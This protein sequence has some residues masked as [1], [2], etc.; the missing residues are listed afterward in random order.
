MRFQRHTLAFLLSF[1]G[2]CSAALGQGNSPQ[3]PSLPGSPGSI[4]VPLAPCRILNTRRDPAD[5][6]AASATRHVDVRAT[7]CGR[8]VPP[9]ALGLALKLVS[10]ST[11]TPGVERTERPVTMPAQANGLLNFNASPNEELSVDVYGYWVAPGTPVGPAT[12]SIVGNAQ[13]A[14][15]P[16]Q[17]MAQAA[18]R[19]VAQD[20]H[21]GN[22]GEIYLDA[23]VSPFTQTGVLM[24]A[25]NSVAPW[26]V[27]KA[28]TADAGSGFV[29]ANSS[30]IQLLSA[31][32]DGAVQLLNGAFLDGRT[33]YFGLGSQYYGFVAVPTNIVHDVTLIDPHDAAGGAT[34]RVV[35][36]NA[37]TDA[38]Y[39][40]PNITKYRAFTD[41][42]DSHTHINYE[43]A[44]RR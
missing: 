41:G 12:Q 25:P 10:Y 28:G 14:A 23:S 18:G 34:T 38:E 7:R 29:L 6:I 19:P 37:Q 11:A 4:F 2:I 16:F 33:D 27:A 26:I 44:E 22:K 35:F 1:L 39:G 24:S 43:A 5:N 9:Y 21:P 8:I 13:A 17:P 40:S 36:Y 20:V 15:S 32:S 30:N 3:A 31:R 42:W